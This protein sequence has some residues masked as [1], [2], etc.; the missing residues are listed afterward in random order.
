[1]QA[2]RKQQNLAWRNRQFVSIGSTG[3][4]DNS[5]DVS[6]SES[7]VVLVEGLFTLVIVAVAHYLKLFVISSDVVENEVLALA[8]NVGDP[9]RNTCLLFLEH[10]LFGVFQVGANELAHCQLHIELVWI[11]VGFWGLLQLIHH[12]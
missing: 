10:S 8:T 7:R 5:N 1:M 9:S 3:L 11:G 4:S 12:C 2:G 6:S